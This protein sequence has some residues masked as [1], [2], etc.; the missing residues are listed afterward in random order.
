MITQSSRFGP[1]LSQLPLIFEVKNKEDGKPIEGFEVE[2]DGKKEELDGDKTKTLFAFDTVL[3]VIKVTK[4]GFKEAEVKD[5]KVI[6]GENKI[7]LELEI[8]KVKKY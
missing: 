5:Y 2:V 8:K 6:D 3:K 1:F 4:V 7:K